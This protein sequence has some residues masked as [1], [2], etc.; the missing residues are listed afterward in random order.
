MEEAEPPEPTV[1]PNDEAAC[2]TTAAGGEADLGVDP[3]QLESGSRLDAWLAALDESVFTLTVGDAHGERLSP[4]PASLHVR[5]ARTTP[6]AAHA[7]A[8]R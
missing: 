6:P 8:L 3:A 4:S 5:R 7:H 1:A 2:V